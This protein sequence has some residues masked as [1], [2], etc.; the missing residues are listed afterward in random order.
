MGAL[1]RLTQEA[2]S[3]AVSLGDE[4]VAVT[5]EACEPDA[6][7]CAAAEALRRD[8]ELWNPQVPLVSVVS[9]RRELTRPLVG[10]LQELAAAHA[11]D[12][13]TVLIPEVEP[14]H[15]WQWPLHNQRG[16]LISRAVRH[17]T[18]AAVCRLRLRLDA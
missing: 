16:A 18:T 5:V 12:R 6:E 2:L 1:S 11:Y 9:A 15:W 14:A 8:W 3:T 4:V 7:E 10:Y 17:G 13:V